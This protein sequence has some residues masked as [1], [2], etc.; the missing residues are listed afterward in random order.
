MPAA[1]G[2]CL[3]SPQVIKSIGPHVATFHIEDRATGARIEL[4][5]TAEELRAAA[6]EVDLLFHAKETT[7]VALALAEL[8]D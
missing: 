3:R 4:C 2:N 5:L 8:E 1:T 7:E 6:D